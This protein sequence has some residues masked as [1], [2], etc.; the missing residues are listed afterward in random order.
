ML[1]LVNFHLFVNGL[2]MVN[3]KHVLWAKKDWKVQI[4]VLLILFYS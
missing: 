3:S 2:E 1:V 4:I